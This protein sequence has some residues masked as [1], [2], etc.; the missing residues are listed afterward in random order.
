MRGRVDRTDS[1]PFGE[2]QSPP[3][4]LNV[5]LINFMWFHFIFIQFISLYWLPCNS[6]IRFHADS[7][8]LIWRY[9]NTKTSVPY[10]IQSYINLVNIANMIDRI[11]LHLSMKLSSSHSPTAF[12][13]I[14]SSA[15]G[16]CEDSLLHV[17]SWLS[18]SW[19]GQT[20]YWIRSTLNVLLQM[21]NR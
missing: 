13:S 11:F 9:A 3:K 21:D 18:K 1:C 2:N 19:H 15:C 7:I 10:L 16:T 12:L 17:L 14:C 6:L 5:K 20:P 8:L 4:I